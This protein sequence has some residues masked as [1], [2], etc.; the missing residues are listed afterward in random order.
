MNRQPHPDGAKAQARQVYLQHGSRKAAEA[1]GISRRTINAWARADGWQQA[2][3]RSHLRVAPVPSARQP[4]PKGQVASL[5]YGYTRRVLLRQLAD[6]ARE[7][8]MALAKDREA[9]KSGAAR[10]WAWC[11]GILLERAE[12]LAKAAGPDQAGDRPDAAE[13]VARIREMAADLAARRT[14][15]D[16]QPP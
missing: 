7:C 6:E 12:L 13:A 14:G 15:S 3:Q 11:V 5:G 2:G 16:G 9:G 4:A 8:L 1:T 10:N